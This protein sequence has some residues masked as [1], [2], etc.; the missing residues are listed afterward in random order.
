MSHYYDEGREF[1]DIPGGVGTP[2]GS[3]DGAYEWFNWIQSVLFPPEPEF[4]VGRTYLA[5]DWTGAV[6]PELVSGTSTASI[7]E[8]PENVDRRDVPSDEEELL[9]PAADDP[10]WGTVTTAPTSERR[11]SV[12]D[13][14]GQ[15]VDTLSPYYTPG[16]SQAGIDY[17]ERGE[18]MGWYS[19]LDETFFGGMLPGGAPPT[20][21]AAVPTWPDAIPYDAFNANGVNGNGVAP[22]PGPGAPPAM[23]G[24][25]PI[26]DPY[27]GCVYKRVCGEWR[28]VK[29]KRRRRKQLFTQR[30]AQQMSSLLGSLPTGAAGVAIA[31]T[32]IASHPS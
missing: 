21:G 8:V 26:E 13:V 15:I 12:I 9:M 2:V 4:P 27:K 22:S 11:V 25:C 6:I 10:R 3:V 18:D 32:W 29:Q 5:V 31:K 30:D 16:I 7:F 28:W 23:A 17:M 1:S 14:N 24:G 20:G 19:D